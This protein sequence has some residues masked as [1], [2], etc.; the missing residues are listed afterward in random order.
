MQS[1]AYRGQVRWLQ[2]YRSVAIIPRDPYDI[3]A[4][5]AKR[6]LRDRALSL[7]AEQQATYRRAI[8]L[9][10]EHGPCCRRCWRWEAFRGL[11]YDLIARHRWPAPRLAM[12]VQALDGC[13]GSWRGAQLDWPA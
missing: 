8:G 4:G 2:R 12:L 10:R 6:L 11:S 13:G 9:A 5:M 1:G 7:T 3:P